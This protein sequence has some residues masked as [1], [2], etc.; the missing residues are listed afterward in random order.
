MSSDNREFD[1]VI[2]GATGFTGFFVVR[3]LLLTIDKKRNEYAHLK[4]AVAG[5]NL[6]KLNEVL[7]KVGTE[8]GK[9]LTE[10]AK[11]QADVQ[12]AKSLTAMAERTK[13]VINTVGPYGFY[14]RPVVEA[15]INAG[16]HH[17]DIS[18]EPHYIEKVQVDF[19]AKAEEKGVLVISTCGWDSIPCDIGVD[20]LKRNFDGKIHSVETFM[21]TRPGPEV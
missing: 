1:L 19:N 14:G 12:D 4:W 18:G 9:D 20:F 7:I 2:F 16:T 17:I 13:L 11:I 6:T 10:V 21:R 3:E 8:L 5:R 15:C